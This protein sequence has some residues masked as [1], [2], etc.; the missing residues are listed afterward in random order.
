MD[1]KSRINTIDSKIIVCISIRS[2][3]DG[4]SILDTIDADLNVGDQMIA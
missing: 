3:R 1:A 4:D 2:V